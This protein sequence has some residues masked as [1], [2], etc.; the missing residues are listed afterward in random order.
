MPATKCKLRLLQLQRV[1]DYLQVENAYIKNRT[2]AK[3]E[4]GLP[5]VHVFLSLSFIGERT[6]HR[7]YPRFTSYYQYC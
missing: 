7:I 1:Y 2:E 3:K 4:D 5:E 6:H